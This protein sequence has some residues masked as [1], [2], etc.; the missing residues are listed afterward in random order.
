MNAYKQEEREKNKQVFRNE[1]D[2]VPVYLQ[3]TDR[4]TE[5]DKRRKEGLTDS[6]SIC[7]W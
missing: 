3:V 4:Q 5:R 7:S 2:I 6:S 1:R